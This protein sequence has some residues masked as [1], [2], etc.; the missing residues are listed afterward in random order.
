MDKFF[1]YSK[2]LMISNS[3]REN[4]NKENQKYYKNQSTSKGKYKNIQS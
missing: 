1:K 4:E 3:S 2:D